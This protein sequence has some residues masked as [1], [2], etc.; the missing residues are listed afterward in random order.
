MLACLRPGQLVWTLL[1]ASRRFLI[2]S[3]FTR[4][5]TG[6]KRRHGMPLV[7]SSGYLFRSF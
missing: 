1:W 4:K 5:R 2:A 6:A 7:V 3:G